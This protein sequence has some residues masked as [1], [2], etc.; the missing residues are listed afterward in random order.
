[1]GIKKYG[2]GIKILA[3]GGRMVKRK[4]RASANRVVLKVW[5]NDTNREI[6]NK[7]WLSVKFFCNETEIE[8]DVLHFRRRYIRDTMLTALIDGLKNLGYKIEI[9]EVEHGK[10]N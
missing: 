3:Q 4:G 5:D 7:H 9:K 6:K 10:E 8:G 1:M 2:L